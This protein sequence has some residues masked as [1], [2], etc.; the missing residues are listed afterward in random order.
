MLCGALKASPLSLSPSLNESAAAPLVLS[1]CCRREV[2]LKGNSSRRG[3]ALCSS[4]A[5][6]L[7]GA[8]SPASVFIFHK[9]SSQPCQRVNDN[10]EGRPFLNA[11]GAERPWEKP[12]WPW[13]CQD[14]GTNFFRHTKL[15]T[16][17]WCLLPSALVPHEAQGWPV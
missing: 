13:L 10:I 14:S 9:Q 6:T 1:A 11:A 16:G 8:L 15:C 12:R 7:H 17:P 5:S 2:L 3:E 4:P